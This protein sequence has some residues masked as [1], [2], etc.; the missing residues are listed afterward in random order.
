V[1][2]LYVPCSGVACLADS[3]RIVAGDGEA[4]GGL[5][6]LV[7][8]G[9][10]SDISASLPAVRYVALPDRIGEDGLQPYALRLA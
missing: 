7:C 2:L 10:G 5:D 1:P 8:R 4:L 9:R 6:R 3:P